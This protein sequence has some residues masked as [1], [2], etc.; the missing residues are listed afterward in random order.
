MVPYYVTAAYNRRK[1]KATSVFD[2]FRDFQEEASMAILISCRN[3][4]SITLM[5]NI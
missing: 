2:G 5:Q 3:D 4:M 1:R